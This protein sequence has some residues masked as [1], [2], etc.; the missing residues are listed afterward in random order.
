MTI[1]EEDVQR[2][3][4]NIPKLDHIKQDGIGKILIGEGVELAQDGQECTFDL[5]QIPYHVA[6]RIVKYVDF[7]V[8]PILRAEEKLRK[9]DQKILEKE[10]KQEERRSKSK[11]K[12]RPA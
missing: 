5:K 3:V 2:T 9:R 7:V 4:E 10:R 8:K 1:L 6:M 11:S 12:A